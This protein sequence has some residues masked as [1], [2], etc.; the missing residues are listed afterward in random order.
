MPPFF[1]INLGGDMDFLHQEAASLFSI[2]EQKPM[3]LV[4]AREYHH[5]ALRA[6]ILDNNL[7]AN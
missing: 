1:I 7:G 2:V 3:H 6:Q 4:P 5:D